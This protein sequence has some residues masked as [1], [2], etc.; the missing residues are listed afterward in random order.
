VPTLWFF[1]GADAFS[2]GLV[3]TRE[4]GKFGYMDATLTVRIPCTWDFA[5][6]FEAGTAV[7]CSGCTPGAP[8]APGADASKWGY[9]D[10]TG[11]VVIPV[12][13]TREAL[14]PRPAP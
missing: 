4:N 12:E 9:I 14:P 13:H 2:D 11:R 1:D 3:R 8:P 6:P 10:R 5:F 7:V